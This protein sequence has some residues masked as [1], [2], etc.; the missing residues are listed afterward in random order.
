MEANE[1]TSTETYV[2]DLRDAIATDPGNG[3]EYAAAVGLIEAIA[4]RR[5]YGRFGTHTTGMTAADRL[6]EICRVL[7]ALGFVAG[8]ES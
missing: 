2:E 3:L 1:N 6:D 8:V 7:D 4:R 5:R